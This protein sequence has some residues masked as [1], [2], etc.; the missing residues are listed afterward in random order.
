M[1]ELERTRAAN[2]AKFEARIIEIEDSID[3]VDKSLDL[4]NGLMSDELSL[5]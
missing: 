5:V 3:A 4:L 2:K 1:K